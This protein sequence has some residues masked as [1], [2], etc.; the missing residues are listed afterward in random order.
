MRFPKDAKG[1]QIAVLL[2]QQQNPEWN[3]KQIAS[4]FKLSVRRIQQIR[5]LLQEL[6]QS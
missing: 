5:E 4:L 2:I 3:N 6:E 1:M